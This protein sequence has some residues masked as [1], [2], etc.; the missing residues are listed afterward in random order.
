MVAGI[1]ALL[2]DRVQLSS[3]T[4]E[5][6]YAI[7]DASVPQWGYTGAEG[8]EVLSAHPVCYK[9]QDEMKLQPVF[10]YL[11]PPPV[12]DIKIRARANGEDYI[13]AGALSAGSTIQPSGAL[14][15]I[16]T[17]GAV[18]YR[19]DFQVDWALSFDGG[20]SW[21]GMGATVNKVFVTWGAPLNPPL[22]EPLLYYG[23]VLGKG[24]GASGS[25]PL[26][27][28]LWVPFSQRALDIIHF[29]PSR[30][31]RPLTYYK[32]PFPEYDTHSIVTEEEMLEYDGECG[33]FARLWDQ[34]LASQG[35][36]S[37]VKGVWTVDPAE[38]FLV[39]SWFFSEAPTWP[40]SV[41]AYLNEAPDAIREVLINADDEEIYRWHPDIRRSS[42]QYEWVGEPEVSDDPGGLPGQGVQNPYSD[43]GTHYLVLQNDILYD[44]S[45]GLTFQ[46]LKEWE[47]S[48]IEALFRIDVVLAPDGHANMFILKLRRNVYQ[49][50]D[51]TDL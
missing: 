41:Y 25:Q 17:G 16:G 51:I 38:N 32:H 24:V 10:S 27:D 8:E 11:G 19:P 28:K 42:H 50:D 21:E 30:Q 44:P 20:A 48:S 26:L 23:C 7:K 6:G 31:V 2:L 33:A 1:E 9:R 18:D 45:Y 36:L 35:M 14:I 46:S 37:S 29:H 12:G 5:E 49:Y 15:A 43:F 39:K 4:F 3:V 22:R 13:V 47:E 34:V 40:D